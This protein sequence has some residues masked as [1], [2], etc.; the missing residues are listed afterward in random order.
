MFE[1][2]IRNIASLITSGKCVLFIGAGISAGAGLP[3]WEE[4]ITKL[5]NELSQRLRDDS[6]SKTNADWLTIAQAYEQ[7]FSKE[8][9]QTKLQILTDTKSKKFTKVH[10]L[11]PTLGIDVWVTTNYD[12]FLE[13]ALAA[14]GHRYR[15]VVEDA[16]I[17][18]IIPHEKILIKLHGD[19]RLPCSMILTKND[20]FRSQQT[21]DLIWKKMCVFLAERS[22][23]FIGYSV[24]DP[25]LSQIQTSIVHQ[26]GKSR[27]PQSYAIMT[28]KIDKIRLE[29]L[30][31]RNISVID[32][33][34][35]VTSD[36][37]ETVF[38]FLNR[39]I[40][41]ISQ[42]PSISPECHRAG[43]NALVP[44]DAKKELEEKG[45]RLFLCIEYR[46]YC[47]YLDEGQSTTV[48]PAWQPPIPLKL[49]QSQYHTVRYRR[50]DSAC[51]NIWEGIAAGKKIN[52]TN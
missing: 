40:E 21:R 14:S 31:S 4:L 35:N 13:Q 46:V 6:V 9:L 10:K 51:E 26:L 15:V 42:Y 1:S 30:A 2:E 18:D 38:S 3:S 49:R 24:N 47:R 45:Y 50:S 28:T 33:S 39:L 19:A 5:T 44:P 12:D 16:N 25:D 37:T 48:L 52:S 22:F 43:A 27:V 8:E 11:L 23:L 17:P 7:C 36:P 41:V 34:G 32:L 20:F 29:D